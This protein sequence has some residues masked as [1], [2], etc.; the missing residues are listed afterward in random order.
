[1]SY[2]CKSHDI[3]IDEATTHGIEI[4]PKESNGMPLDLTDFDVIFTSEDE[5][6]TIEKVCSIDENKIMLVLNPSETSFPF[7]IEGNVFIRP[8]Q[9][10]AFKDDTVYQIA[11][12]NMIIHK[13][14]K[15]YTQKPI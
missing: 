8:Y 15:G 14:H 3:N 1:M 11:S 5:I 7:E 12:G 4:T 13:V 9:I 10:R 6:N 2:V